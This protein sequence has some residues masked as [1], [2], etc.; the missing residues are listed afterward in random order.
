MEFS[1]EL[2]GPGWAQAQIRDGDQVARLTASYLSDALHDLLSGVQRMLAGSPLEEFSWSEEPG[3]YNW[4]LKTEGHRTL[5]T[6]AST[7][8]IRRE[9]QWN[10]EGWDIDLVD[11]DGPD[12]IEFQTEADAVDLATA[13]AMAARKLIAKDGEAGYLHRWIEHPFPTST[14]AAIENI[15]SQRARA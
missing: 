9:E 12:V 7:A 15:L 1:Y 4:R 6:I 3:E 14:L 8:D 11:E 10:D 13:I 2:V 5:V